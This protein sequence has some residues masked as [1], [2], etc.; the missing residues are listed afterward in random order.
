MSEAVRL[1][2]DPA[3]AAAALE[4][5]VAELRAGRL[6]IYPTDTLY[7]FGGAALTPGVAERV[8]AA[9]GRDEGKPLP[10][11]AA[12]EEQARALA[13]D[14]NQAAALLAASFWPGPLTLVLRV[15]PSVPA[16]VTSGAPGVAVRVPG[17]ALTRALCRGA[18]PLVSTSA[19]RPRSTARR[20][21]RASASRRRWRWMRAGS[22]HAPRRSSTW[23]K[24]RRDCFERAPSRGTPSSPSCA[25]GRRR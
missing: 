13:S 20:P 3:Q 12:D 15:S 14:W 23:P 1:A 5:A 18:G 17:L 11:V 4:R 16:A 9:K 7:A 2:V 10:L 19:N 22:C 24:G 8:R 25:A 6:L 21:W